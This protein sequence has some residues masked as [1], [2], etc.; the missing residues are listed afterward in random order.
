MNKAG[1]EFLLSGNGG[2]MCTTTALGSGA[3]IYVWLGKLAIVKSDT[4]FKVAKQ[5]QDKNLCNVTYDNLPPCDSMHNAGK[6][7]SCSGKNCKLT[8]VL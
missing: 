2:E 6:K 5:A 1:H 7:S 4:T 8:R 3:V